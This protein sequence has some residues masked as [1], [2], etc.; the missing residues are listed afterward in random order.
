LRSAGQAAGLAAGLAGESFWRQLC[1]LGAGGE[2]GV[3]A[4]ATGWAASRWRSWSLA[5]QFATC[6][7]IVLVPAMLVTGHWVSGRLEEGATHRVGS[8]ALLYMENFVEPLVQ[9]LVIGDA[10][11]PAAID[12]LGRILQ[13]TTLGQR[14]VSFK[15]WRHDGAV[16]AGSRPELIG[17]RFP[18]SAGLNGAFRGIPKV[19]FDHLTAVENV[20]EQ[21]LGFPILEI[22]VPLRARGSDRI[23]AVGEF[24]ER[25]TELKTELKRAQLLSW[26]VVGGVTVS[27]LS[28]LFAIVQRGSRTIERQTAALEQR[29]GELTVLLE[30]N[31]LL[32]ERARQASARASESNE[33]FLRRLGADLHDGPAQLISAV[34]LR[35]DSG[36]DQPDKPRKVLDTTYVRTVLTDALKD[37][38]NLARGLAVPEIDALGLDAAL[39]HAIEQHQ[40]VTG[41]RVMVTL[42]ALPS[43]P[44]SLKLCAYRFVQEGLTNAFRHAGGVGQTVDARVDT[45]DIVVTVT[46]AGGGT[47]GS[48]DGSPPNGRD[49]RMA[50]GFGLRALSDRIESIGGTLSVDHCAIHGTRLVARLP[51]FRVETMELGDGNQYA[52]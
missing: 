47:G 14:V 5:R 12:Q 17:Q 4:W 32:R 46:D 28:A 7:S 27:M 51:I 20:Y 34:L 48:S 9:D 39:K 18:M 49:E 35:V 23:I 44:Q 41:T 15:I 50:S 43:V 2:R 29:V 13:E 24:Y 8:T 21:K 31:Q 30:E 45:G 11:S 37:I 22:Y 42:A 6:A 19:E 25:A 38:R 1:N 16:I 33:G 52:S 26:L 10:L 36:Q 3:G 40:S